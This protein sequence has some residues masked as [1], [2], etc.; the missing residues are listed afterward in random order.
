MGGD[1]E[2]LGRVID[3]ARSMVGEQFQIA[4]R[5]DRK[6][7]YQVATAGAFFAV[8]QAVAVNAITAGEALD[9]W[10]VTLAAFAVPSALLTV[11]A[12]AIATVAWRTQ[13]ERDLPIG[14]LR[15]MVDADPNTARDP[16]LD[17]AFHYLNLAEERRRGNARRLE[18]VRRVADVTTLSIVLTGVELILLLIGLASQRG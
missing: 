5:L 13:A 7:R 15:E 4:E 16:S 1:A 12:F 11:G 17:L 3:S 2:R 6:V 9:G 18:W 14:E 10:T 8:V